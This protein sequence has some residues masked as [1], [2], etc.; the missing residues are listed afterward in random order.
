[1]PRDTPVPDDSETWKD[2]AAR[3]QTLENQIDFIAAGRNV[4]PLEF[5]PLFETTEIRNRLVGK[6][7]LLSFTW[8][9][10]GLFQ[11]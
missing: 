7:R 2:F 3:S 4:I 10:F 1:M 6:Q 8:T 5:P 9:N 11:A